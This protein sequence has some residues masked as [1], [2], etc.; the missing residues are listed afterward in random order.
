MASTPSSPNRAKAAWSVGGPISGSASSFQ[1]PVCRMVPY[2]VRITSACASGRE[3]ATGM[4]CSLNGPISNEP[5]GGT[6][7]TRTSLTSPASPSL[8]FSTAAANG[9]AY[10]GQRSC[11]HRWATAPMWSS[12]AWVI[13]RASRSSRRSAMKAGSGIMIS[14]SGFSLPPKPMPQSMASHLPLARYRLRFMPI[15]PVP[16]KGRKARSPL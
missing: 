16:P 11:R 7:W 5:P 9:V 14:T 6:T 4:N 1:S 2:D 15:S 8:R 13:T 10:T 3:C 12:C